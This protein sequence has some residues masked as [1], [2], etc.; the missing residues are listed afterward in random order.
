LA[1]MISSDRA[2]RTAACFDV[3]DGDEGLWA[4]AYLCTLFWRCGSIV[5]GRRARTVV[6]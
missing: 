5:I 3:A 2:F 1:L 6:A 4:H